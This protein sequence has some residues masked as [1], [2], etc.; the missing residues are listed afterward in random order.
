MST[1]LTVEVGHHQGEARLAQEFNTCRQLWAEVLRV[2]VADAR[3][4]GYMPN[5]TRQVA[6]AI[7]TVTRDRAREW[8]TSDEQQVGSFL[9]IC[10]LLELEPSAVRKALQLEAP[11]P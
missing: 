4:E 8:L 7:R 11:P 9:W 10:S 3:G 5:G 6:A 1:R 2:A